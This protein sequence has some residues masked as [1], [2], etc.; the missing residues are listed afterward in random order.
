MPIHELT[1]LFFLQL[2]FILAV[3]RLV[4]LL[5]RRLQ[6]P[7]VVGE[8][9]GGV[10]VGPSLLGACWPAGHAALFPAESTPLIYALSQLGLVLY[11][12]LVGAEFDL[13]LLRR[14]LRSAAAVAGAGIA[15]PFSLGAGA[16]YYLARDT[17]LFSPRVE[18]WEAMLFTGAAMAITAFPMLARIIQERGLTGTTLGTLVLA[19]GGVNDAAAWCILAVVLASFAGDVAIAL[20]AV[21]GGAVYAAACWWIL[22]PLL[23]RWAEKAG[24][25][26]RLDGNTWVVLLVLLLAGAWFTDYVRIYAVFGAFILG[27]AMPRGRLTRELQRGCGPLTTYLLVPLFFVYSGLHTRL[28]QL[29]SPERWGL[30]LVLVALACAGKGVACWLAA[31]LHGEAHRDALAVGVLMNARGM[32]E[33]LLLNIGLEQGLITP[34]FFTLMVAMTIVTTLMATPLFELI[35]RHAPRPA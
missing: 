30:L 16:A 31:R 13:G 17:G 15:V 2:A 10:L 14:H 7:Q 5:L 32:M 22:R 19:A 28:D 35:Y 18:V 23:R 20:R 11:M 21:V 3:T 24:D 12:F 8:M 29:V 9:V 26:G 6:Q 25:E 34:T 4:G 27:M 1:V 33:L